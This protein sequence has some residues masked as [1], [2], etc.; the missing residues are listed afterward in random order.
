MCFDYLGIEIEYR[1]KGIDEKGYIVSCKNP[2]YQLP[3][4]KEV[5]SIDPKYFRPSEVDILVGDVSKAKALLEWEP[6]YDL[7]MLVNEMMQEEL[8][9]ESKY[10]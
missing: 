7:Q 8:K 6:T 9:K 5:I 1:G 2:L 3:Y 10:F 4:N